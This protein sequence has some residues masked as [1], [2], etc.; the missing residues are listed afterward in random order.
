MDTWDGA[1]ASRLFLFTHHQRRS[2]KTQNL[3]C[4]CCL[5]QFSPIFRRKCSLQC[6]GIY[7]PASVHMLLSQ[8][9]LKHTQI[10]TKV[11]WAQMHLVFLTGRSHNRSLCLL[12]ARLIPALLVH[13]ALRALSYLLQWKWTAAAEGLSSP[14]QLINMGLHRSGRESRIQRK[15]RG[16]KV[17]IKT[18]HHLNQQ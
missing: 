2:K 17:L 13:K 8:H 16:Y 12:T 4:C 6:T 11:N 7:L 18:I 5:Y 9:P 14:W 1:Q 3:S 15:A 10:Q